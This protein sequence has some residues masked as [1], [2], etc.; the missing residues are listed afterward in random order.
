M[1]LFLPKLSS[2]KEVDEAVKAVAE[3]VLVLRFGRDEDS[4]CMQLDEI[5]S[6]TSH[7]LKNMTSIYLV[8][9]DKV[10]VYTRYFDIS[11]IPS[12]VFFF[13]GQHMKVDYGSPDHTK[14][15]GCFKTKQDFIDLIEVIYRGAMRGKLIVQSPIDPRN[16]PKYDLL[17]HDI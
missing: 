10:P 13:N 3:K 5:L 14:F 1:S 17:Y 11:Y 7:D 4:V 6:K 15:I 2:K 16:I 12:T 8:D 9:V